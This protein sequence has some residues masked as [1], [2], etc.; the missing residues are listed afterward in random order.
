[1]IAPSDRLN[2]MPVWIAPNPMPATLTHFNT[3]GS[4]LILSGPGWITGVEVNTTATSGTLTLYDGTDATGYVMAV[5]DVSKQA[6]SPGS[7]TPW[8]CKNG[9]FIVLSGNADITVVAHAA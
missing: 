7:G 2:A 3:A 5:I 4:Y 8:P 1:M 9:L 6:P